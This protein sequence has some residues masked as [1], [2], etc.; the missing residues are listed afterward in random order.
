[1]AFDYAV[2]GDDAGA[3]I[4]AN[5]KRLDAALAEGLRPPPRLTVAEWAERYRRFPDDSAY[6]GKWK[7]S[8]AIYLVEIMEALSLHD[9]CEEVVILKCAQSGGTAAIENWIGY[10]SDVAPGPMLFA[11]A[12]LKAALEWA[13]EKLWPMIDATPRLSPAHG[14][15]IKAQG[16]PDGDGSTK[17]KVRFARSNGFVVLAGMNSGP[18]LRSRTV[19]YAVEDDLDQAPDDIEGQG[20]PEVMVDQR[21]KVYRRRGL[22]KRA[23]ISTPTI[24]GASKIGAAHATT[25]RRRFYLKCPHCGSRFDPV[26]SDL[27]WPD[28][29]PAETYLSPPCCGADVQ[30][31]QKGEMSLADGWLSED[32]DGVRS[33]RVLTEDDFQAHR[34]RM[35]QSLR[36]GFHI[37]GA[38]TSFQTWADLATSFLACQGDLNKLKGWTNLDWGDLFELKGSTPDYEKLRDLREQD[39]GRGQMPVG[40]AVATMGVDVQGDGLYVE[41]VA[42]AENAESWSL[43]ARFLPGATD[44]SGEGAWADLDQLARQPITYPGGRT[45]PIDQVC[46]DAGYNTAAAEAFCRAHPNRLAVFGRAGWHRPILGRGESLR[47]ERQGSKTGQASKRIEDKAYLVGTY[48]VKLGWYGYLRSTI[49]AAADELAGGETQRPRGRCHFNRDAPDEWFE[50]ITSET[51]VVSMANGY[52]KKEWKPLPGR[53]NHWLDCRVYNTAAAE[54][55]MLDTLGEADWARLRADRYAPR[56]PNQG[57]LLALASPTAPFAPPPAAPPARQA[58]DRS[59]IDAEGDYL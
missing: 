57:D 4:E 20:S 52:P 49:R 59:F 48:G 19:R 51:I 18:S 50:Q 28:G 40:P 47:Y 38:F 23:K 13:G 12:T 17:N 9:P 56:D 53:P 58:V 36:R 10:I 21:L 31:W 15:T 24:K 2:F 11:Q 33:P 16:Q 39:W 1:M 46:V 45:Y 26:F 55:L 22:A 8:T 7:H 5:A 25:D 44:V 29:A 42:W 37:T 34:A 43:D 35:P 6:P 54:K 41:I 30:H 3:A 27:R 14:G 32:I